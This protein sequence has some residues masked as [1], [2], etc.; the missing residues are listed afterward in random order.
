MTRLGSDI[1][2]VDK[3]VYL[4]ETLQ[5]DVDYKTEG[6]R[7]YPTDESDNQIH[8]LKV[9]KWG[10]VP[11]QAYVTDIQWKNTE[12]VYK[13]IVCIDR[14]IE[15]AKGNILDTL[16][17]ENPLYILFLGLEKDKLITFFHTQELGPIFLES[18]N[19]ITI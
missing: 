11:I 2:A 12:K 18:N 4:Y 9:Q 8:I 13:P 7:I 10:R 6:I 14:E 19:I 16:E 5:E 3:V 15:D 1:E 17:L